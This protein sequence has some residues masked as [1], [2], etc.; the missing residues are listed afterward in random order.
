M[1]KLKKQWVLPLNSVARSIAE[2]MAPTKASTKAKSSS[3][4]N[5]KYSDELIQE[6]RDCFEVNG[7]TYKEICNLYSTISQTYLNQILNY[8]V[9][10]N[11][12]VQ[13]QLTNR[14]FPDTRGTTEGRYYE[15][16]I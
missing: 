4:S 13:K 16:N 1:T 15:K 11:I 8:H 14:H 9:R 2:N 12:S 6:I 10:A 7:K 3:S 5:T